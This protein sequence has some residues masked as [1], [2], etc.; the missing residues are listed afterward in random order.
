M[1]VTLVMS[2]MAT[3]QHPAGGTDMNSVQTHG[4]QIVFTALAALPRSQGS[5]L[6][7]SAGADFKRLTG[8]T[9]AQP[10]H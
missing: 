4:F 6:L 9:G 3:I 10:T 2:S 8:K 5:A 7:H 1:S